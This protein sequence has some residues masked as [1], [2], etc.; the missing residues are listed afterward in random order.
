MAQQ[1]I[2][3][4]MQPTGSLHLGN[5]EGALKNW[6]SLQD[7]YEMYCCIVDWHSLTSLY[8]KTEV[9]KDQI[10]QMAVD[11]VAAGLDPE[12]CAIFV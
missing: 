4:G 2:L 7:D 5:Y 3:S 6:I 11:Y 12:K 9:L 8:D 10:F 1:V